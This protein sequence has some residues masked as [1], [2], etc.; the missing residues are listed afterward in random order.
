MPSDG[1]NASLLSLDSLSQHFQSSFEIGVALEP[2]QLA[3]EGA[4][5]AHHFCRLTAENAMKWGPLCP[6]QGQY[7]WERADAIADFARRHRMHMTGHTLL[8]HNM[9]PAWLFR[10]GGQIASKTVLSERLREHIF[11]VVERYADV[12]DN[13]DV[14]NEAIS[15]RPGT[16]WRDAQE[17]SEWYAIYGDAE[18]VELAFRYATEAIERFAP[19]TRL[20]YN[21]YD[22]EN[23]EK[24][25]KV[26]EMVRLLRQKGVRVDGVGIQGHINL[27][28]PTL[29]QL[30]CA[31]DEFAAENLLVKV[32][33]L[34]VSV[35][36]EDNRDQKVFQPPVTDCTEVEE[37]VSNR[38]LDVFRVF[39]QR[40]R[41]LTSV[42]FWGLSDDRTWLN[43]FPIR[44]P[45]YPLL[46]DREHKAKQ[47]L[48][49][50]LAL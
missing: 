38:Y 39:K 23:A 47:G 48:S 20:Y 42:V 35:Y 4:A 46:I 25:T 30:G 24:R 12:V 14:V 36:T 43:A 33:E 19:S 45:N 22:I 18:F 16:L 50:L 17:H 49:R 37:A 44:R 31:I 1:A 6:N 26:I 21:D 3:Q 29:S 28:W 10:D 41:N 15:D 5:V 9:Q 40:S 32:S 2:E 7:A 13:W 27:K 11:R 8:W 34:D